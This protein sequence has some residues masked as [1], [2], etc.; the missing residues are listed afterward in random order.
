MTL[1]LPTVT[2]AG[3]A[4][5]DS[6]LS[7]TAHVA[8]KRPHTVLVAAEASRQLSALAH[9]RQLVAATQSAHINCWQGSCDD[10]RLC[11]DA[12]VVVDV[13]AVGAGVRRVVG[14]AKVRTPV[15]ARVVLPAGESVGDVVGAGAGEGTVQ[16]ASDSLVI[17][18]VGHGSPL[19]LG[20]R[21]TVCVSMRRQ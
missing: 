13:D 4:P 20:S 6:T 9:H 18:G 12:A 16:H 7:L 15:V 11:C 5:S 21:V 1:S 10:V 8:E 17:N 3:P 2:E 14:V 19:Q